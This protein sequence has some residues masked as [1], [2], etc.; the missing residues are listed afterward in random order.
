[1]FLPMTENSYSELWSMAQSQLQPY[2]APRRQ[3]IVL[4]LHLRTTES[5]SRSEH[6]HRRKS[7]H[8]TPFPVLVSSGWHNS[9]INFA[10][11]M[12]ALHESPEVSFTE[13]KSPAAI[14]FRS[15][16]IFFLHVSW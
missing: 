10:L 12:S 13:N 14:I 7:P 6:I 9:F 11:H 1:M 2:D 15:A 16:I 8:M 3:A 4:A 5:A